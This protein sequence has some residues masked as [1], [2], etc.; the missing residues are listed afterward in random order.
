MP[1]CDS[2]CAHT[3]AQGLPRLSNVDVLLAVRSLYFD[4]AGDAEPVMLE[5]LLKV[6][7]PTH[8]LYGSDWPY[9]RRHSPCARQRLCSTV[10]T[11]R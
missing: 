2:G 3:A 10:R 7:D 4:L 11:P 5:A 8:L 6:A 9:T 1:T